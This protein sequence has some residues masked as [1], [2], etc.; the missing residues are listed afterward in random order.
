MSNIRKFTWQEFYR[1][2]AEKIIKKYNSDKLWTEKELR[3]I[4]ND[5]IKKGLLY[6]DLDSKISEYWNKNIENRIDPFT[7]FANFNRWIKNENR[8]V[9]LEDLNEKFELW[10]KDISGDYLVPVVNNQS[11]W[12]FT[13]ALSKWDKDIDNLWKLFEKWFKWEVDSKLF[14]IVKDQPVI[15]IAKLTM[16]LFWINPDKY[17]SLDKNT[18]FYLYNRFKIDSYNSEFN[19]DEY[20]KILENKKLRKDWFEKIVTD[21]YFVIR[22]KADLI[23]KADE[24]NNELR[25][26]WISVMDRLKQISIILFWLYLSEIENLKLI[27]DEL[28]YNPEKDY[29]VG[30][31]NDIFEKIINNDDK[32]ISSIFRDVKIDKNFE[33][34]INDF[35][36]KLDIEIL[37]NVWDYEW[38]LFWDLYEYFLKTISDAGNLWEFYTP[39]HIVD[40]M[41]FILKQKWFNLKNDKIYDPTCGTGWFLSYIWQEFK[42]KKWDEKNIYWNELNWDTQ[43]FA[44]MNMFLHGDWNSNITQWDSLE[45]KHIDEIKEKNIKYVIANPPY[46]A[47]WLDSNNIL[48]NNWFKGY[49][50][51]NKI[52]KK[53]LETKT[54]ELLFLQQIFSI[55]LPGWTASVII[56][57]WVNFQSWAAKNIREFLLA[58]CSEFEVFSLPAWAFMPYTWV[59]TS[60]YV[61][62]KKT[63]KNEFC[64]SVKFFDIKNDGYS[65]DKKRRE[66]SWSD[67][68]KIKENYWTKKGFK[69][70]EDEWVLYEQN[71]EELEKNNFS[72]SIKKEE[73]IREY[74]WEMVE[75]GNI[76]EVIT[77][78]SF[79]AKSFNEQKQWIPV[80]RIRDIKEWVTKNHYILEE[81]EKLDDFKDFLVRKNDILI[82]MD[83]EFNVWKWNSEDAY[84]NQR[85]MKINKVID[86]KKCYLDYLFWII[87]K[88][89]KDLEENTYSVTVKHLSTSWFYWIKIPLPPLEEQK[90]IVAKL[91][92]LGDLWKLSR[93]LYEVLENIWVEDDFFENEEWDKIT[94]EKLIDNQILKL[95]WWKRLPQWKDFLSNESIYK[96]LSVEWFWNHWKINW[97]INFIDE[98]TY[99]I[100]KKYEL[101]NWDIWISIAWS[102]WRIILCK[103][104]NNVILTENACKITCL[105]SLNNKYLLYFLYSSKSQK[106]FWSVI[107]QW[108]IKKLSLEKIKALELKNIS[109]YHQKQIAKY[110]HT[111]FLLKDFI[112]IFS[113]DIWS[114]DYIKFLQNKILESFLNRK[115][116]DNLDIILN[117]LENTFEEEKYFEEEIFNKVYNKIIELIDLDNFK[118]EENSEIIKNILSVEWIE[119]ENIDKIILSLNS[120]KEYWNNEIFEHLKQN[121]ET[122]L[123]EKELNKW[124]IFN[125]ELYKKIKS[126]NKTYLDNKKLFKNWTDEDDFEKSFIHFNKH[127]VCIFDTFSKELQILTQPLNFKFKESKVF[128]ELEKYSSVVLNYLADEIKQNFIFDYSK[129]K[130]NTSSSKNYIISNDLEKISEK[131][132]E[133]YYFDEK[134]ILNYYLSLLTKQ[135]VILYWITGIWKSKIASEFPKHIYWEDISWNYFKHIAIKAWWDDDKDIKWYYDNLE[136]DYREWEMLNIIKKAIIDRKNPYFV[137]LD[138]MNISKVEHYLS[139]F[140]SYIETISHK[141]NFISENEIN[142]YNTQVLDYLEEIKVYLEKLVIQNTFWNKEKLEEDNEVYENLFKKHEIYKNFYK[143]LSVESKT[144]LNLIWDLLENNPI[145]WVNSLI[146]SYEDKKILEN[147]LKYIKLQLWENIWE[148]KDGSIKDYLNFIEEN[149]N[150]IFLWKIDDVA[151]KIKKDL[152]YL[153]NNKNISSVVN[154]VE[155]LSKNLNDSKNIFLFNTLYDFLSIV[156]LK[157]FKIKK[158]YDF[159]KIWDIINIQFWEVIIKDDFDL[160][161]KLF[162]IIWK[163]EKIKKYYLKKD[164]SEVI[165]GKD[166]FEKSW[167]YII[168]NLIKND[169]IVSYRIENS[170]RNKIVHNSIILYDTEEE[171]NWINK[172]YIDA[173]DKLEIGYKQE[174]LSDSILDKNILTLKISN[175]NYF[176][177]F[178]YLSD[179]N[180]KKSERSKLSKEEQLVDFKNKLIWKIKEWYSIKLSWSNWEN[181]FKNILSLTLKEIENAKFEIWVRIPDNLYITWTINIDETT[182]WLSPKVIDRA[183]II[184]YNQIYLNKETEFLDF[185]DSKVGD[186]EKLKLSKIKPF[187]F[188]NDPKIYDIK[189][190]IWKEKLEAELKEQ[191]ILL[192]KIYFITQETNQHFWYRTIEEIL[193]YMW[194]C[195]TR[196]SDNEEILT[197]FFDLQILQ[198]I[199]PKIWWYNQKTEL[200]LRKI[201]KELVVV[202]KNSIND[203]IIFQEKLLREWKNTQNIVELKDKLSFLNDTNKDEKLIK[204]E[205][206]SIIDKYN[207]YFWKKLWNEWWGFLMDWSN[208]IEEL[209]KIIIN[210][211][212][213]L[214]NK[215]N[216]IKK[217]LEKKYDTKIET[218][219]ITIF[220]KDSN[221]DSIDDKKTILTKDKDNLINNTTYKKSVE[222][223]INMLEN[224]YQE[225][226]TSYFI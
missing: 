38:D 162:D 47:K 147:F 26:V 43:K 172:T 185:L 192:K 140:L 75:L 107:N 126:L 74:K 158:D 167:K 53:D 91:E 10:F 96:Y 94:L 65:L 61:F 154:Y 33:K 108:T 69:S 173:R 31:I 132:N 117:I 214:S 57:E 46:W 223:I 204:E 51:K 44:L 201:L 148:V 27:K 212:N 86:S 19:F 139:D 68:L 183:N 63:D 79:N 194:N 1:S 58:N 141:D 208:K 71:I 25:N 70:L 123:L 121:L 21:A 55:L 110:F 131:I 93:D 190:N 178:I 224:Y 189:E 39:R 52:L 119:Q 2:L 114:T 11:A 198:K 127:L 115:D 15:W 78:F 151:N 128:S 199:L 80:I 166:Y 215:N 89:L 176:S 8:K 135:F 81:K 138:E 113:L 5:W 103:N 97:K 32:K 36:K 210:E 102:P 17:I 99:S 4:M 67:I 116:N 191:I 111:Y 186:K 155:I 221:N 130:D 18:R 203:K 211:L 35:I 84:L 49:F 144:W 95:S 184:E 92:K 143:L 13:G 7:F 54:S 83:W 159:E 73:K 168:T 163:P 216:A 3:E 42:Y 149:L 122:V 136:Q 179:Y 6:M 22:T 125:Y 59:K 195:K 88:P 40:L 137:L 90:K 161:L 222:K 106:Y 156:D 152:W 62:T 196:I 160:I 225:G 112:K 164:E 87:Q 217:I 197:E 60:F 45:Q 181:K 12:F 193:K 66:I 118:I 202:S 226:K 101:Y 218:N 82:W 76:C 180:F 182:E 20:L 171:I 175:K 64:K 34:Y 145:F 205:I 14:D 72:L 134:D 41:V 219:N 37:S 133:K 28:K 50:E 165:F 142:L 104:I 150:N 24:L 100:L 23:R 169:F 146:W 157:G 177:D 124:E 187:N 129:L 98:E 56:P 200:V 206:Y 220:D 85:V 29:N 120:L 170:Q 174:K 16:W 209:K 188:K 77:W 207:F 213:S 153:V 30:K 105:K 109:L 48:W 9:I